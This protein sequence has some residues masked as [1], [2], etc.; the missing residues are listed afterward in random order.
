ML[1]I[2]PVALIQKIESEITS[3]DTLFDADTPVDRFKKRVIPKLLRNVIDYIKA[4][5]T[6]EAEEVVHGHNT[7]QPYY[8]AFECSVCGYEDWD[9][10][11]CEPS[12]HNYCPNCGAKID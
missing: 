12:R 3:V 2:D 4:Q 9:T 7:K 8:D 11:T 1:L 10:M 6:I 5:P